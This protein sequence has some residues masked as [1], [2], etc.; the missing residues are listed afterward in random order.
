[1]LS[2]YA[3]YD[4]KEWAEKL[5]GCAI[6]P[7]ECMVDR[8]LGDRG[9]CGVD[10][11]LNVA[12]VVIHHGEEPVISGSD[13]ICNVFFSGCNLGCIFCQNHQISDP[14]NAVVHG[15]LSYRDTLD[16]IAKALSVGCRNLGFVTP[17]HMVPQMLLVHEAIKDRGFHPVIVYNS[18]G[19]DRPETIDALTEV[20]DVWLPDMKYSD[21]HLA[22]RL[23]SARDY[24]EVAMKAISRM[25][26]AKGTTLRIE[27]GLAVSGLIIRHLV[28]PGEVE[29]SLGVL[30][31][32]E[33]RFGAD[34][35]IS[36]MSQYHPGHTVNKDT[37]LG[38]MLYAE[39][40]HQVVDE[41]E[42]LG[43]HKGWVQSMDSPVNY[44][45]DFSSGDPFSDQ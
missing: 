37:S 22:A 23:S 44:L 42:R 10:A 33:D 12:S 7:R 43:F 18:S 19:Y 45:P 35:A 40:Y 39:E 34:V 27:D 14:G 38:R 26:H 25:Y 17:S 30:R 24:P 3:K 32:I 21:P 2:L 16:Q 8:I 15:V 36:L 4:L 11:G 1:M 41:M 28:L 13:G 29:N 5:S 31:L 6:C 20:V 9:I